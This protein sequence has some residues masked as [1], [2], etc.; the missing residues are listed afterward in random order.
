MTRAEVVHYIAYFLGAMF[1]RGETIEIR[2]LHPPA[3]GAKSLTTANFVAAAEFAYTWN[4]AGWNCYF[5]INPVTPDRGRH[6]C[7]R[8]KHVVR[9]NDLYIDID[10]ERVGVAKEMKSKVCS[11][12]QEK[13]ACS[14]VLQK[15]RDLLEG[16]FGWP[17]PVYTD[18]GSGLNLHH[19]VT[20]DCKP[21][22]AT[23]ELLLRY[24][25]QQCDTERAHV[26]PS[27]YGASRAARLPGTVNRKGEHTLERPQRLAHVIDWALGAPRLTQAQFDHAIAEAGIQV[28][29][30]FDPEIV[31]P[32]TAKEKQAGERLIVDL[33][34]LYPGHLRLANRKPKVERSK[35][36][37]YLA[38]CPWVE[39]KHEGSH[40][41]IVLHANGNLGYICFAGTCPCNVPD[42][43][44]F[45][46]LLPHLRDLTGVDSPLRRKLYPTEE[47]LQAAFP[48]E[49]L[50]PLLEGCD[51][52]IPF[53]EAAPAP[54]AAPPPPPA[55]IA[56]AAPEPLEEEPPPTLDIALHPATAP[57]P[58]PE[59]APVQP[60]ASTKRLHIDF[61]TRSEAD[62][63]IVGL[64]NY[65]EHASTELLLLGWA[66]DEDPVQVVDFTAGETLPPELLAALTDP[67]IEKVAWNAAFEVCGV[68]TKLDVAVDLRQWTD[69]SVLARY[70]GFPFG[71]EDCTVA[72]HLA[73]T[74]DGRGKDLIKTFSSRTKAK[75]KQIKMG[76]AELYW[77]TAATDPESWDCFKDY[78]A[79]DVAVMRDAFRELESYTGL[80]AHEQ[81]VWRFDLMVNFVGLPV[82]LQ[83][84]DH[85]IELVDAADEAFTAELIALTGVENPGSPEQMKCWCA[86]QGYAMESIAEEPVAEA[87][88]DPEL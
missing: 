46:D 8:D 66:F 42:K 70:L 52:P 13:Q 48:C 32:M 60:P 9:R 50:G 65:W 16:R 74:K 39:R 45:K 15:V 36:L 22:P 14:E 26:D 84:V 83:Y 79:I 19:L 56:P 27:V 53:P 12:D 5:V 6:A 31:A 67:T 28:P 20:D 3:R 73:Q 88:K 1:H 25:A 44:R 55:A 35:T 64:D 34:E 2:V 61:E 63:K 85:G 81:S 40:S 87:L 54:A 7:A 69:P 59:R 24:L 30:K 49:M 62:L 41:C 29:P 18:S 4:Q 76:V 82:D 57:R 71:L 10:P 72:L 43:L 47:E 86:Q 21:D 77:R 68:L 33:L 78:C 80:P 75:V 11:T 37:Y 38:A 51:E 58:E 23:W 17:S